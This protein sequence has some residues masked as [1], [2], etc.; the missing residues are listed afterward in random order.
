MDMLKE[1]QVEVMSSLVATL[2]ADPAA[3]KR[4][5]DVH[6]TFWR[7]YLADADEEELSDFL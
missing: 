1:G 5:I 6:N 7:G 3:R 2:P 4:V